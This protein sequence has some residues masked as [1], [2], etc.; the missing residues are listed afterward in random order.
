MADR[1]R[2]L[3][4]RRARRARGRGGEDAAP[5]GPDAGSVRAT[6]EL[7]LARVLDYTGLEPVPRSPAWRRSPA[8]SGSP[9]TWPSSASS[10][11]PLEARAAA[12]ISLPRPLEGS[13][14]ARARGGRRRRGRGRGRLRVAA[15]PRPVPGLPDPG[16]EA[17]ADAD[18]GAQPGPR[19]P[20]ARRR[21]GS[22]SALGRDPR[23][24]ALRPVRRRALATRARRRPGRAPDR[25]GVG[26]G[27]CGGACRRSLAAW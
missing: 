9:R 1:H 24:D 23:A 21:G 22:L 3:G 14:A 16:G 27:R 11:R 19:G 7:A 10:P 25:D 15:R 26:I 6:C 17:A 8:R 12:E 13:C 20:R 18:R 2:R 5:G 4:A